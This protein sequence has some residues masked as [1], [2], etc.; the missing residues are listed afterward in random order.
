M[1][2]LSGNKEI[3]VSRSKC[4]YRKEVF[5]GS[6]CPVLITVTQLYVTVLFNLW[7]F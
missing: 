2:K 6:R 4:L 1:N 5:R 3:P 7:T